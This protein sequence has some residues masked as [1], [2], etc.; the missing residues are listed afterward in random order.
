LL[1]FNFT[2]SERGL[3]LFR[4]FHILWRGSRSTDVGSSGLYFLPQH[5]F[6]LDH[7]VSFV[8]RRASV[9]LY[10]SG[11]PIDLQVMVLKP[12][13]V[14]DHALLSKARDS[15]ECSFEVG[16]VMENYIYHFRDLTCFVGGAVHVVH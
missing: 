5:L 4:V 12:G 16:F 11:L 3:V 15:E 7:T 8:L 2:C 9:H 13:I 14:K 6:F 1:I 10:L